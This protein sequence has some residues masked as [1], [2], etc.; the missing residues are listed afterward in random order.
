MPTEPEAPS[1]PAV[2]AEPS[3]PSA[4]AGKTLVVYFSAPVAER[5]GQ[6][7][8]ISSASRTTDTGS[9]KGNTQYI[10]E[11]ISRE[12]NADLFEIEAANAY[13]DTYDQMVKRAR[14]EQDANARPAMKNQVSD[15]SQYSTI[16]IGYPIWWSD[17]PQ[18]LYTFFDAYDL[19]GKEIIPF[20]THAGSGLSGTVGRITSLEP[21]AEVY[22][23]LA[24][25][26]L[27]VVFV[28][29]KKIVKS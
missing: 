11:L 29:L 5:Q 23:G 27:A 28:K 13:P 4:S 15:I 17:M 14:E 2:P 6:V 21:D 9:Y 22:S 24:T 18:I 25:V 3:V 19:S 26:I 12:T 7:D 1:E 10:A 20:C 8:G 16:Y